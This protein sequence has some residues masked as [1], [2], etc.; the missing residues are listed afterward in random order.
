M[1]ARTGWEETYPGQQWEHLDSPAVVGCDA[2]GYWWEVLV[3][4]PSYS[5]WE[6]LGRE[7]SLG[8]GSAASLADAMTQAETCWATAQAEEAANDAYYEAL[9]LEAE[10]GEPRTSEGT[11]RP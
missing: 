3:M 2:D 4:L 10:A 6:D 7:I 5:R 8:A 11:E 9:A 1:T